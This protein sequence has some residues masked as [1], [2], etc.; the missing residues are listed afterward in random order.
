MLVLPL[1]SISTASLAFISASA[2]CTCSRRASGV[3]AG[4]GMR[5]LMTW[6]WV[7]KGISGRGI[8]RG[9]YAGGAWIAGVAPVASDVT[10]D[11][12]RQPVG[13]VLA[14]PEARAHPRRRRGMRRQRQPPQPARRRLRQFAGILGPA[15][16][17][18]GRQRR[19][20]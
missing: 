15:P 18:G 12:G 16:G 14:G 6:A 2:A 20:Q 1:T 3:G 9:L 13:H 19:R 8:R 4:T 7:V 10:G 17:D 11:R 5:V